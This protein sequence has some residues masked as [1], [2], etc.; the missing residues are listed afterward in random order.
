MC[1]TAVLP[2]CINA[3]GLYYLPSLRLLPC[4][5]HLLLPTLLPAHAQVESSQRMIRIVGLSAT[6]P[7]YQ[8]VAAF[9]RVNAASGLF[10]FDASYRC[11]FAAALYPAGD[12]QI[13][14]DAG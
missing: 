6:L 13:H 5:P 7:N 8:D 2:G 14:N 10:H 9:L 11:K 12:A 3:S 4:W 1:I